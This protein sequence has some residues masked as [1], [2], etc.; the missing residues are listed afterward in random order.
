MPCS[1]PDNIIMVNSALALISMVF[2][3]GLRHGFDLDHLAT[4]DAMTRSV[5]PH[6]FYAR[7]CGFFF[8]LGHGLVVILISFIVSRGLLS[9]HI[10]QWLDQVGQIISIIFLLI[11]SIITLWQSLRSDTQILAGAKTLLSRRLLPRN[12]T[13]FMMMTVGALFAF[14]FDTFSQ[15]AFFSLSASQH[16][17]SMLPILL[18]IIFM[19]GMMVSDGLNGIVVSRLLNGAQHFSATL[20]R[21][22]GLAISAFSFSIACMGI[23][24]ILRGG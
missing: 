11:F 23:L 22:A 17:G 6:T 3:L 13:P 14:S 9:E 16:T 19:I 8:S 10:P 5:N 18:G 4:I 12:L 1:S 7:L 20:Y 21:L 2:M 15:V 24:E